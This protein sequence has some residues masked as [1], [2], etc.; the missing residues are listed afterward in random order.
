MWGGT[1]R[2][3]ER[4]AEGIGLADPD[5][6]VKVYNIPKS[7][8]NDIITEVFKSKTIVMGSPTVNNSILHSVAGLA[9]I[10]KQMKFKDKKAASFGCHG[11][12]GESTKVI[13][14][15]LEDAGFNS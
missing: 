1:K 12:S 10:M 5:V 15:L 3:A 14:T 4:I 8:E 11:W 13:N 2:L 9:H 7:D 6:V